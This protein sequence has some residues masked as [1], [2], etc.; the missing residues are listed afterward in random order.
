[1]SFGV[2][3]EHPVLGQFGPIEMAVIDIELASREE[4]QTVFDMVY[5]FLCRLQDVWDVDMRKPSGRVD[6][7][8]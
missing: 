6:E 1:M 4:E 8:T 5:T 3:P 7:R 2:A